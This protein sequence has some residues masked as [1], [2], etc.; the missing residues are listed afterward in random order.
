MGSHAIFKAPGLGAR[1]L[2]PQPGSE[3]GECARGCCSSP[4]PWA[5]CG[6]GG[7]VLGGVSASHHFP[8]NPARTGLPDKYPS[9]ALVLLA[10]LQVKMKAG[11]GGNGLSDGR[12]L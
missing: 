4:L 8:K 9:S 12:A 7:S 2:K 6:V 1:S 11:S 3:G 10:P 5:G